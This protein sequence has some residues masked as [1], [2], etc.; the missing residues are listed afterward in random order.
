MLLQKINGLILLV[1]LIVVFTSCTETK[2]LAGN[3]L[4]N[5][6]RSPGATGVT[7]QQ[8]NV[9]TEVKKIEEGSSLLKIT[10]INTPSFPMLGTQL[11]LSASDITSRGVSVA[12]NKTFYFLDEP[13][14][15]ILNP[16]G[17]Q[18]ERFTYFTRNYG[19]QSIS[20]PIK[21]RSR[22]G[23]DNLIPPGVETSF[24]FGTALVMKNSWNYFRLK[25][26]F[27]GKK[28]TQLSLSPGLGIGFGT[29]DLDPLTNAPGLGTKRKSATFNYGGLFL[30]GLNNLHF[31]YAIGFDKAMGAGGSN[32]TYNDVL[33]QGIALSVDILKF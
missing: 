11:A 16:A 1:T 23:K 21:F 17:F 15:N 4:Y 7:K 2:I 13:A 25:A 8:A 27:L 30:V 18:N 6:D 14:D 12:S 20:I 31:G 32:W 5:Y 28:T 22:Q 26:N 10:F 19:L 29:A 3:I 9:S 24:N 33:W